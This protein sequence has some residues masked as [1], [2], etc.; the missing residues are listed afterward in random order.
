LPNKLKSKFDYV[1]VGELLEHLLNPFNALVNIRKAL[2]PDGILIGTI[3]NPYN[4]TRW[5]TRLLNLEKEEQHVLLFD[6]YEL[7]NMLRFA[8]FEPIIVKRKTFMWLFDCFFG[9]YIFF[10]AR[11]I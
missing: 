3:P 2:K 10:K 8:G 9:Y 6:I 1:V 4:L 5:L 7:K 11:K